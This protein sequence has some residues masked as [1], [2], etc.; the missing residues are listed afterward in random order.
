M[1]HER[2]LLGLRQLRYIP[3]DFGC[4]FTTATTHSLARTVEEPSTDDGG[5]VIEKERVIDGDE[6]MEGEVK[7]VRVSSTS[8]TLP[9]LRLPLSGRQRARIQMPDSGSPKRGRPC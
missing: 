6:L 8:T 3:I 9:R 4:E 5:R 7:Q 2:G 1:S